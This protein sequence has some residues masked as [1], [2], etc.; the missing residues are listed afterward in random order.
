MT[1]RNFFLD[2]A[3]FHFHIF[4]HST[5]F[6]IRKELPE[7]SLYK[8]LHRTSKSS[9]LHD[10]VIYRGIYDFVVCQR[11][12]EV[13]FPGRMLDKLIIQATGAFLNLYTTQT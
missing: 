2:S 8:M 3:F 13:T 6:F 10:H 12:P 5:L 1:V 9:Y 4:Y 7:L 11:V